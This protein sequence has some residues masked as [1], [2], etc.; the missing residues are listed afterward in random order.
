[1]LGGASRPAA[2]AS[3]AR[4]ARQMGYRAVSGDSTP[5][6]RGVKRETACVGGDTATAWMPAFAGMTGPEGARKVRTG[7]CH[8][9]AEAAIPDPASNAAARFSA[10]FSHRPVG[11]PRARRRC[12][13]RPMPRI[14]LDH[15]ATYEDLVK[16][17]DHVVAEIVN[18]E[19]HASPRPAPAHAIA[20]SSLA[21]AATCSFPGK[22]TMIP[23]MCMS[24]A[25]ADLS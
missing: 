24:T 23:V 11:I 17:P 7:S 2:P 12:T 5:E 13:M 6:T 10:S 14:P 19:L 22:A 3:G 20:G 21:V 8:G 1:M 25:T 18:G 15:P 9:I 4:R 16:L